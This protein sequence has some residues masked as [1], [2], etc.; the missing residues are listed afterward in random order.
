MRVL[1]ALDP[2][3]SL[4]STIV[5]QQVSVEAAT[6]Q[7]A[8]LAAFVGDGTRFPTA[9]ELAAVRS[10]CPGSGAGR[11]Q[12]PR[13]HPGRSAAEVADGRIGLGPDADREATS[14]G[15]AAIRG[16][17][18]WTLADVRMRAL[19]DPD[20]WPAG[21]LILRRAIATGGRFA[22]VDPVGC[23]PWRSYLA[24]H[25]WVEPRIGD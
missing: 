21:D 9:T 10:G 8:R 23:R 7:N 2:F 11:P 3:R 18:P 25:V 19:G 12:S 1:G 6:T 5:S 14:A 15:L 20:V 22:G 24:H 4:V 17:G 16:V 13:P